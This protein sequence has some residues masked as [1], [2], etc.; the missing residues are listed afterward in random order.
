MESKKETMDEIIPVMN[1]H[2]YEEYYS[3][4]LKLK[5]DPKYPGKRTFHTIK[6]DVEI[7]KET[8]YAHYNSMKN[9]NGD[10]IDSPR[11]D[12]ESVMDFL[13]RCGF[14]SFEGS[15]KEEHMI[16]HNKLV[17]KYKPKIIVEIGFN[18]GISA[19]N[20]LSKSDD[21]Q[22]ISFDILLHHYCSY[23]KLF[24]DEKYPGRHTLVAGNSS[25]VIPSF[26]KM[27]PEFRAD[28]IFIDGDH[29]LNGAYA[30]IV[31]CYQMATKKTILIADNVVPHRG[32]GSGV[33]D[34]LL[35]AIEDIGIV[36]FRKHVEIGDYIDGFAICKYNVDKQDLFKTKKIDF[37]FIERRFISYYYTYKIQSCESLNLLLEIKK[38]LEKK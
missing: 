21:I 12:K 16:W 7:K 31:N 13:I 3:Q 11:P 32:L 30:D 29:N 8:K 23:A 19:L 37:D 5:E 15:S 4:L 33:Y 1:V 6:S 28:L 27:H 36:N 24:V 14:S 2:N 25:K 26:M 18:T 10:I 20:F 38:D 9:L 22:V 34:A 17:E 35:R